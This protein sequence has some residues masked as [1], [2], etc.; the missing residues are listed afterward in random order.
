M[1]VV[2]TLQHGT[3]EPVDMVQ[4]RDLDDAG[5]ILCVAQLLQAAN[6][7]NPWDPR[8][9]SIRISPEWPQTALHY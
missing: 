7:D 5:I 8:V 4:G 6:R 3:N 9:L 2:A 1:M